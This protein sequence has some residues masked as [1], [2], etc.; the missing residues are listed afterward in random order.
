MELRDANELRVKESNRISAT[1]TNLARMGASIEE[2]ES[3]WLLERGGKL[4]GA[5]LSSFSDHRIAMSCAIAALSADGPSTIEGAR[6][7]VGVSL[8]E[9]WQLLASVAE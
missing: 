3:G 5:Q 7:S 9:F 4:K 2:R 8:P 1:V 6:E